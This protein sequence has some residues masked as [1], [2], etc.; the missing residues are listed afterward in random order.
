MSNPGVGTWPDAFGLQAD[1][2]N[3]FLATSIGDPDRHDVVFGGQI[4]AQMIMA[5]AAAGPGGGKALASLHTVFARAASLRSP[6]EIEVDT[7]HDGRTVGSATITVRQGDRL[8]ARGLAMHQ[9][10]DADVISHQPVMPAVGSPDEGRST[11]GTPAAGLVAPGT[12]VRVDGGVDTWDPTAPTGPAELAVWIRLPTPPE[13]VTAIGEALL[14]YATD[15]FL[16]GTAMRPHAGI[17]Q[18]MAHR[19]LDTGVL[20]HT[21]TFHRPVAVAEWLLLA[22]EGAYAGRGRAYGRAH[23]FDRDGALVASFVQ[24]SLIRQGRS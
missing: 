12:E 21:L 8:C 14:A 6:L 24:E 10:E 17:G 4:L 23:V 3:R 18:E 5:T 9:S 13:P 1:G 2:A 20:T 22:H 16:I 15:G 19:S 11:E 7:M